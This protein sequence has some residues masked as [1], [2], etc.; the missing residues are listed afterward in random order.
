VEALI[1][2]AAACQPPHIAVG[3]A[4][5]PAAWNAA[6]TAAIAWRPGLSV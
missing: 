1:G 5:T 6:S 3:G 2:A 4:A